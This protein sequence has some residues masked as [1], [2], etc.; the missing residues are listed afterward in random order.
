MKAWTRKI[1]PKE[2]Q[3]SVL[4]GEK[5]NTFDHEMSHCVNNFNMIGRQQKLEKP[6]D[7]DGN[8]PASLMAEIELMCIIVFIY[9]YHKRRKIIPA[10]H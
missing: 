3:T 7:L 5:Y 1:L 2:F 6:V 8:L 9:E 10:P 4:E